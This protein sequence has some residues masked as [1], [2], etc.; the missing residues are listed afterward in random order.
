MKPNTVKQLFG[1]LQTIVVALIFFG[2]LAGIFYMV[3]AE[4]RSRT[5]IGVVNA[6]MSV[7]KLLLLAV[8]LACFFGGQLYNISKDK[9]GRQ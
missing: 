3:P 6:V 2:F 5:I 9:R 8:A 1:W 4:D 7:P